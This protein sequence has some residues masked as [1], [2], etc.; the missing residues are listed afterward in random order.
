MGLLEAE[1]EK[2]SEELSF[3]RD[4]AIWWKS[5]RGNAPEPRILEAPDEAEERYE[6]ARV[7]CS[8]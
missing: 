6:R 2:T 8:M 3:R 1:L 4:F 7:Y 5:E